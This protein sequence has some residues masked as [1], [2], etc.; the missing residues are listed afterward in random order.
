MSNSLLQYLEGMLF[1]IRLRFGILF[2]AMIVSN[3]CW[4]FNEGCCYVQSEED[5]CCYM[6]MLFFREARIWVIDLFI[7]IQVVLFSK[8]IN[9]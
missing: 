9:Q 6:Q 2:A 8:K 5:F 4:F 3:L 1:S 7:E